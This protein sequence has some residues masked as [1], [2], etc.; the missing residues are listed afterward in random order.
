MTGPEWS[1]FIL[2]LLFLLAWAYSGGERRETPDAEQYPWPFTLP[3]PSDQAP[4]WKVDPYDYDRYRWWD[5][6]GWTSL[7][8]DRPSS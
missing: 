6:S 5:G 2:V 3:H 8:R 1:A 4:G 7:T